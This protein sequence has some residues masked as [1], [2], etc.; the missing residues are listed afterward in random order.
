MEEQKEEIKISPIQ[1]VLSLMFFF[2]IAMAIFAYANQYVFTIYF[3]SEFNDFESYPDFRYVLLVSQI[4][5]AT[6]VFVGSGF[7]LMKYNQIP[8]NDVVC[9]DTINSK[10]AVFS[11]V[12]IL[13]LFPFVIFLQEEMTNFEFPSELLL[14]EKQAEKMT[15]YL[16]EMKNI[17]DM[18]FVFFVVAIVAGITEEFFFRG[19]LQPLLFN[20]FN[21]IHVA[22][23]VTATIFSLIH[24]QV[25]GFPSR[26]IMGAILGYIML[27]SG[28]VKYA[29]IAHIA[30]NGFQ[31]VLTYFITSSSKDIEMFEETSFPVYVI[32]ISIALTLGLLSYMKNNFYKHEMANDI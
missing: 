27:W 10:K 28:S 30:N 21:N 24:F 31:V 20:L 22:I 19:L 2:F 7:A 16:M 25:Y 15:L 1:P 9:F 17:W 13:S 26:I 32:V 3:Q 18:L 12:I 11:I 5:M 23:W 6:L 4:I 14:A 8:L 29:M